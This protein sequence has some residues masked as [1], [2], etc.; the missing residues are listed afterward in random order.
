MKRFGLFAAVLSLS[1]LVGCGGSGGPSNPGTGPAGFSNASLNGTYV[2]TMAGQCASACASASVIQAVGIFKADGNGNVTNGSLD[3]NIGGAYNGAPLT[4]SGTYSVN[5]DGTATVSVNDTVATDAFVITLANT[6]SGYIVSNDGQWALSG[7]IAKQSTSAIAAAPTAKYV[8]RAGGLT[9]NSH[10]WAM[11]GAM[12]LSTL[13]LNADTN[14]A[15][16]SYLLQTGL[17]TSAAF[18]TAKGRG[19]FTV[20]PSG[21]NP[22]SGMHFVYYVVDGTSLELLTTD[23]SLGLLGHAEVASGAVASPLSGSFSFLAAGFPENGQAQ[24][25]EGGVFTGDGA[26]NLSA[27]IIDSV[28]DTSLETGAT[29]TGS[30]VVS[31]V[32]G[33]TRDRLTL[34]VAN[35]SLSMSGAAVWFASS[36]RGFFVTTDGD[37]AEAGTM[38]LQSGAP[39]TDNGTFAFDQNGWVVS[40]G[41]QGLGIAGL[42]AN[43]SGKVTGYTQVLNQD[44][45][46]SV[47]TGTGTLT[48]NTPGTIGNLTLSSTGV[49][50][51]HFR[52]YQ[53][54]ASS[55]FIMEVDQTAIAS[56]S[57]TVQTKQ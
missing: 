18:D 16:I 21:G 39:F 43:T 42:F 3:L 53:Y 13:A 29:M 14:E 37:R 24:V 36:G 11:A 15:G 57:M 35:S 7:T 25:S 8:F 30:G 19:T 1:F 45:S 2:F 38:N 34:T 41:A 55:G 47:D 51:E 54:S 17:L 46:V 20:V 44:G 33:V 10:A 4:L 32:N 50:D 23:A 49:G 6:T 40:S 26:G 56:G 22:I 12:D 5:S 31:T 28:F 9:A 27:G 52:I 48:F